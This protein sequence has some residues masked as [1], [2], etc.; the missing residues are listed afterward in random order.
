MS[1]KSRKR[2]RYYSWSFEVQSERTNRYGK[3]Y[4]SHFEIFIPEPELEDIRKLSKHPT[5]FVR[6]QSAGR[7]AL[8]GMS[9]TEFFRLPFANMMP[10]EEMN[11]LKSKID[12]YKVHKETLAQDLADELGRD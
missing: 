12:A 2:D 5:I 1:Q 6:F 4:I 7:W 8:Q 11:V 10:D 9:I 3:H